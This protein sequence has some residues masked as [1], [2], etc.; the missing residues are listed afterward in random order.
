MPNLSLGRD[1]V[2]EHER[3]AAQRRWFGRGRWWLALLASRITKQECDENPDAVSDEG[4][5]AKE[6]EDRDEGG[7]ACGLRLS[8]PLRLSEP[9]ESEVGAVGMMVP[10]REESRAPVDCG[11]LLPL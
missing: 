6:N 11:S 9:Y 4:D 8:A 10:V 2:R 5:K 3:S 1:E 7:H